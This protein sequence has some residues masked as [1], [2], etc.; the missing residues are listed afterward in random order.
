MHVRSHVGPLQA[1]DVVVRD[2]QTPGPRRL[3]QDYW[4]ALVK[5]AEAGRFDEALARCRRLR[6]A[7]GRG[8]RPGRCY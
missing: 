6:A 1:L 2:A 5:L 3:G 4:L 8:R 7:R